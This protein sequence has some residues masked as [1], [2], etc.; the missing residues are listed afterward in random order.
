MQTIAPAL[1][2]RALSGLSGVLGTSSA[3]NLAV[4]GLPV[5]LTLQ[6]DRVV[7]I[8]DA[9]D[10]R[11]HAQALA[12]S[13]RCIAT[14]SHVSMRCEECHGHLRDVPTTSQASPARVPALS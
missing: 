6:R 3:L 10:Q 13:K 9:D 11:P 7:T 8:P 4:G 14:G 12:R 5:L 2:W 1:A